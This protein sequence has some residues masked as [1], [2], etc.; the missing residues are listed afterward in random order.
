MS[1]PYAEVIGDP[2]GHSKSPRI[3]GFWLEK[4]G[5]EGDYRATRVEAADLGDYL[6]SRRQD[7]AWRGCNVT[8]PHKISV[9][10]HLEEIESVEVGAVNCIVPDGNRLRGLNTDVRGLSAALEGCDADGPVVLIG[11]GGAAR[12]A[13]AWMKSAGVSEMRV[14]A[15]EPSKGEALLQDF[16]CKGRVFGF[17]DAGRA[18]AGAAGLLNGTPLGMNGFDPM[19][20]VLLEALDTIQPGGFVLDMVYAPVETE[21]LKRARSEGLEALD[22]LAMLIGQAKSAFHLFF[23]ALPPADDDA[24]LRAILTS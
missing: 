20:P 23:G 2:I 14:L 24:E 21:L 18:L 19:P 17:D 1:L 6:A 22:G 9:M 5:I 13:L 11:A 8:I 7:P 10:E 3:H 12:A 4:L 15:R 16:D